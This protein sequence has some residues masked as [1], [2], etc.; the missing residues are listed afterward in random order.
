MMQ[1]FREVTKQSDYFII[2]FPCHSLIQGLLMADEKQN[3]SWVWTIWSA[4]VQIERNW[5]PMSDIKRTLIL[6]LE[7]MSLKVTFKCTK[8]RRTRVWSLR[9]RYLTIIQWEGGDGGGYFSS[10]EAAR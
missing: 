10:R 8:D 2:A 5:G 4:G 6:F 3:Y 7:R 9:E 1:F